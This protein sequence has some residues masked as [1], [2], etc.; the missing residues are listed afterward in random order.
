MSLCKD[1]LRNP[2]STSND[3]EEVGE[4]L[5]TTSNTVKRLEDHSKFVF[6]E[7]IKPDNEIPAYTLHHFGHSQHRISIYVT[8]LRKHLR[9]YDAY[10]RNWGDLLTPFD[11]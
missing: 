3:I 4:E 8:V 5:V 11:F 6:D 7:I 10:L 2:K 9:Y 1:Q